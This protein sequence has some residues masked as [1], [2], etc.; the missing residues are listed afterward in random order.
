MHHHRVHYGSRYSASNTVST[1]NFSSQFYHYK[2]GRPLS[3]STSDGQFYCKHY[4]LLKATQLKCY[5]WRK[6][7]PIAMLCFQ[8]SFLFKMPQRKVR[9]VKEVWT[10]EK[11]HTAKHIMKKRVQMR[12]SAMP[13]QS[14]FVLGLHSTRKKIQNKCYQCVMLTV[15]VFFNRMHFSAPLRQSV[16]GIKIFNCLILFIFEWTW[17]W[18]NLKSKFLSR[19]Q[20][21]EYENK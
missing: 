15:G 13:N 9:E 18:V 20:L 10:E 19:F 4:T 21:V 1:G 11:T 16:V 14:H 2:N 17:K 8:L 5:N 7:C 3:T 6:C 12:L